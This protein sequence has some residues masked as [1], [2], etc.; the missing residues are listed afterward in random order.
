MSNGVDKINQA[1]VAA[2]AGLGTQVFLEF[3]TDVVCNQPNVAQAIQD[4]AHCPW[5]VLTAIASFLGITGSRLWRDAGTEA[6]KRQVVHHLLSDRAEAEKFLRA[7]RAETTLQQVENQIEHQKYV[8]KILGLQTCLAEVRERLNANAAGKGQGL[9]RE[10]V[11]ALLQE[12][13]AKRNNFVEDIFAKQEILM[14]DFIA[15][16]IDNRFYDLEDE[17]RRY[18]ADFHSRIRKDVG[19]RPKLYM[20]INSSE[21]EE[22]DFTSGDTNLFL[23]EYQWV[24]FV[25]RPEKKQI[26][27]F[28]N[29][30][31]S[32]LA[33][34]MMT[35][36]GG[37]G[38]SRLAL[39]VAL[40]Y[41][42]KGW[43]AGF[44]DKD[45]LKEAPTEAWVPNKPTLIMV[46]YAA[47]D[48]ISLGK[49]IGKIK[50]QA[51]NFA[52][53]VRFLFLDRDVE[54]DWVEKLSAGR[55]GFSEALKKSA[56]RGW[57]EPYL[58]LSH[59]DKD[60][61]WQIFRFILKGV[62]E[63]EKEEILTAFRQIDDK[64]RPLYASLAAYAMAKGEDIRHWVTK[65]P[66]NKGNYLCEWVLGHHRS[67]W[68]R[69][70]VDPECDEGRLC[71]HLLLLATLAAKITLPC[72]GNR[73][74]EVPKD[75]LPDIVPEL[76]QRYRIMSGQGVIENCQGPETS[77]TFPPLEPDPLGE[78]LVLREWG[79]GYA[80]R[81]TML[82]LWQTAWK[83]DPPGAVMFLSR[84]VMDYPDEE[85]L[86]AMFD[87]VFQNPR[88]P[89]T[90][91]RRKI[92]AW[93]AVL[94]VG[95]FSKRKFVKIDKIVP[96]IEVLEGLTRKYPD[97][98][99]LR[100]AWAKVMYIRCI[101][102]YLNEPRE[103]AI[104]AYDELIDR[105]GQDDPVAIRELVAT[106]LFNR[107][108][109]FI[110]ME[111]RGETDR[112]APTPKSAGTP[113]EPGR[114]GEAIRGYDTL[115][116]RYPNPEGPILRRL[117]AD[118]DYNRGKLREPRYDLEEIRT[119]VD[120]VAPEGKD[121]KGLYDAHQQEKETYERVRT[122][123]R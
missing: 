69:K 65:V 3:M 105:F 64:G 9:G 19:N 23:F 86:E 30:P 51:E 25:D 28:L 26:E 44:I 116:A 91:E 80:R 101:V 82:A 55:E 68:K 8:R 42:D 47:E 66:G 70:G 15:A 14:K 56:F 72:R 103:N 118:A 59:L 33:W 120:G 89:G 1:G 46:D 6:E 102:V 81:Q 10:E 121:L 34:C 20:K 53:P 79:G 76:R 71:F 88:D 99:E 97:E 112:E 52:Y 100:A 75:L 114:I 78:Y 115:V 41:E 43:Y 85:G 117:V 24:P 35:G 95:F 61:I 123:K 7:F 63:E 77:M 84:M 94:G 18:S 49:Y 50:S 73:F 37:S 67:V 4:A 122:L 39:E 62:L 96:V 74:H 29:A 108:G 107:A 48:P 104:R 31:G 57:S 12:E 109:C 54:P 2:I 119:R 113:S 60:Q 111:V 17:I 11:Q 93:M 27:T 87:G 13:L 83:F 22:K 36:P 106:A 110:E 16:Y 40:K 92:W 5:F 32:P 21:V 90:P 58:R 98:V 45:W 38:K